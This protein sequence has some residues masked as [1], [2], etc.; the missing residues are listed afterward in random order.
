MVNYFGSDGVLSFIMNPMSLL[1]G[2]IF[3]LG[4]LIGRKQINDNMDR[5]FSVIGASAGGILGFIIMDNI[6]HTL[7]FSIGVGLI[8]WAAAGFLLAEIIGDG[9]TGGS[10]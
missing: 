5:G 9:Q 3:V 6:F 7:K 8:A 2:A 4:A 10:A 1:F